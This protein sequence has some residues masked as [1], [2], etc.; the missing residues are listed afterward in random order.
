[1]LRSLVLWLSRSLFLSSPGMGDCC[2]AWWAE[3]GARGCLC[4]YMWAGEESEGLC[5]C[6][7]ECG[8]WVRMWD[9]RRS[10]LPEFK[11]RQAKSIAQATRAAPS[12]LCLVAGSPTAQWFPIIEQSNV[13]H[14]LNYSVAPRGLREPS[15]C[16]H[17]CV[18]DAWVSVCVCCYC[19]CFSFFSLHGSISS[20]RVVTISSRSSIPGFFSFFCVSCVHFFPLLFNFDV[21]RLRR[22]RQ[23]Q[24]ASSSF[25]FNISVSSTCIWCVL[26]FGSGGRRRILLLSTLPL[27]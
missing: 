1:M 20:S 24:R 10:C 15:M 23:R 13:S 2:G 19:C 12:L 22:R 9:I 7:C 11:R 21:L 17:V 18:R 6:V 3:R 16:V 5:A 25:P 4:V 8:F 27:I 26:L 14:S